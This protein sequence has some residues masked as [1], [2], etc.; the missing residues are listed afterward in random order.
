MSCTPL[1]ALALPRRETPDTICLLL[2]IF[3][4]GTY[5]P[6]ILL[7]KLGLVQ[8][9][10]RTS[11]KFAPLWYLQLKRAQYGAGQEQ[12]KK[13]KT[14]KRKGPLRSQTKWSQRPCQGKLDRATKKKPRDKKG[15]KNTKR[16]KRNIKKDIILVFNSWPSCPW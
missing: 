1:W 7:E 9:L 11:E 12:H 16:K 4:M 10:G 15:H 5:T 14:K 2:G 3:I 8:M 13:I 6:C